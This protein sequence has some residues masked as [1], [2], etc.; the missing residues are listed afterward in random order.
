MIEVKHLRLMAAIDRHG[1]LSGAARELG[2]SQPAITQQM[3]RL[4]R[5]LA[6]PLVTKQS[7]GVTLTS[8]GRV[9]LRHAAQ[10]LPALQRAESEIAAIA[11]L[12]GGEIRISAFASGAAALLP[13]ALARMAQEHP[14]I[15]FR[16][17]EA[18][19][20]QSLELLRKGDC[21]IALVY[22][23]HSEGMTMRRPD[24]QHD[25]DEI[26]QIAME[27]HIWLAMPR[28]HPLAADAE[29]NVADLSGAR[30][31]SGCPSC[32]GNLVDV[33]SVAGFRPDITY[34]T[35]D[36]IALQ[37]LAAAG[38]GVAL[39]PDLMLTVTRRDTDLVLKPLSQKRYRRVSVVTTKALGAVPGVMETMQ[40]IVD[41]GGSLLLPQSVTQDS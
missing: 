31:I 27:E 36:Y 18:E 32:Q 20:E 21:E 29:V 10:V 1:T 26:W 22:E 35:D 38:L 2:L 40:A 8:A 39:L 5:D 33:C 37:G 11:G 14:G 17:G 25:P 9:L 16:L 30:W 6:T 41:V 15:S 3:Q 12:R 23:Y 24:L 7:R 34:E 28:S 13:K 4:E 19:T